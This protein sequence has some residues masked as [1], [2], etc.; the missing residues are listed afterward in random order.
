MGKNIRNI[1][2]TF[3]RLIIILLSIL[4]IIFLKD[5]K[6]IKNVIPIFSIKENSE[7]IGIIKIPKIN[8]KEYLYKIDSEEN[9]IEKNITIL[10]ESSFPSIIFL[11]AHSGEG[12]IAY[13][14]KLDQLELN[15][16]IILTMN[17]KKY[18][19][20]VKEIWEEKK[21][22]YINVNKE[23]ENQLILTTCSPKKD[24]TQLIIN[25]IEKESN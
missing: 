20:I 22:G 24:N 5:N 1:I 10:K 18:Y 15:D 23:I 2:Y 8:L 11:A 12:K 25:C 7:R 21:N 13:F 3:I 6:E 4:I 9:T 19:Y 16:E 14:E 17:K